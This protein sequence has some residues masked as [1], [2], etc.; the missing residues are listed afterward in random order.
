MALSPED[1]FWYFIRYS[2]IM[3]MHLVQTSFCFSKLSPALGH[4]VLYY[5]YSDFTVI[6]LFAPDNQN[7]SEGVL[8]VLRSNARIWS[9]SITLWA[10]F[11]IAVVLSLKPWNWTKVQLRRERFSEQRPQ[12]HSW[13][14][15]GPKKVSMRPAAFHRLHKHH[16]C[17]VHACEHVL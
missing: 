11:P 15:S 17:I 13:A 14:W 3:K 4:Q 8:I 2:W 6:T 1:Y 10:L 7:Q 16:T 5:L 9:C 12:W